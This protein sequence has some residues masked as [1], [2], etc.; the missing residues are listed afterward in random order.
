MIVTFT[1]TGEACDSQCRDTV[2]LLETAGRRYLHD[3]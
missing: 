3:T 1:G 2:V